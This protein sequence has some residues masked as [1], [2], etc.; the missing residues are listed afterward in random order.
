MDENKLFDKFL[1]YFKDN[2]Y[3]NYNT[4][5]ER[6]PV[7]WIDNEAEL[8]DLI[9]TAFIRFCEINKLEITKELLTS[10]VIFSSSC[11]S[12]LATKRR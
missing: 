6:I 10:I 8:T 1:K 9:V 7:N 2:Y 3:D 5:L 11:F 4:L 12:E